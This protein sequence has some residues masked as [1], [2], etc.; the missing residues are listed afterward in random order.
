[1]GLL[2]QIALGLI[3]L[4]FSRSPTKR[5]ADTY[6]VIYLCGTDYANGAAGFFRKMEGQPTPPEFLSTYPNPATA[7]KILMLKV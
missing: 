4:K 1:M 7:W 5:K 2:E 6:S 3:S